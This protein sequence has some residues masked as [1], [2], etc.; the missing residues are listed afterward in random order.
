LI[1]QDEDWEAACESARAATAIYRR[2][3]DF[4]GV[5]HA[6]RLLIKA[7]LLEVDH[8]RLEAH[9]GS[10]KLAR[11]TL[12]KADGICFK[13]LEYFRE[14]GNKYGEASTLWTL[15]DLSVADRGKEKRDQGQAWATEALGMFRELQDGVMEARALMTLSAVHV[16]ESRAD[17]AV[18]CA[19]IAVNICREGDDS[20]ML[21]KALRCLAE[22]HWSKQDSSFAIDILMEALKN[23]RGISDRRLEVSLLETMG[24]WQLARERPREAL[25]PVKEAL[26]ILEDIDTAKSCSV[27]AMKVIVEAY[28]AVGDLDAALRE[29]NNG[30]NQCK[31]KPN[32][33]METI[34]HCLLA[35]VHLARAEVQDALKHGD[36]AYT[37]VGEAYDAK[38]TSSVLQSCYEV[39]CGIGYYEH[40]LYCQQ[41][42]AKLKAEQNDM[43]GE[44]LALISQLQAVQKLG[45]KA[46]QAKHIEEE[47]RRSHMSIFTGKP[48]ID[49]IKL[50]R[51]NIGTTRSL[52][53]QLELDLP[54]HPSLLGKALLELVKAGM[55][56]KKDLLVAANEAIGFFNIAGDLWN[57]AEAWSVLAGVHLKL[58]Q[59]EKALEAAK[60]CRKLWQ[61]G[62]RRRKAAN[63]Y[64]LEGEIQLAMEDFTESM[65]AAWQGQFECKGC[66][67]AHGEVAA[68]IL[69]MQAAVGKMRKDGTSLEKK[70][71]E[72]VERAAKDAKRVALKLLD[73]NL[74]NA[75]FW[76]ASVM[77][78]TGNHEE[79]LELISEALPLYKEL[80][81]TIGEA[82]LQLRASSC[83]DN[84]K[85]QREA[86]KA[87]EAAL[88]LFQEA[89]F[90]EGITKAIAVLQKFGALGSGPSMP[91]PMQMQRPA[92]MEESTPSKGE[93][94]AEESTSQQI[95][96][97]PS[98]DFIK[99]QIIRMVEESMT[100]GEE[101]TGDSAL[102]DAGLDSLAA[103]SFRNSL[104]TEFEVTLPASLIFDYPTISDITSYIHSLADG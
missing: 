78:M 3:G 96:N 52:R 46:L 6:T 28:L 44:L 62:D 32:W 11:D 40:A 95:S 66:E 22:A 77:D 53:G 10:E 99:K 94:N 17:Q 1:N 81:N 19:R 15:A 31:E 87:A 60:T 75:I 84:L 103:V 9:F 97:R 5:A 58:N 56:D 83:Y 23:C 37:A 86:I 51:E 25:P 59:K 7:Y 30:L 20:I 43:I 89:E 34:M 79:A 55:G 14:N 8:V 26:A 12:K 45:T 63:S 68:L 24:S 98:K 91:M 33:R 102:M 85:R 2:L 4:R 71:L 76:H 93:S 29:A 50:I 67:D 80:K 16:E 100:E 21:V 49:A 72:K 36:A 35:K 74:P 47:V 64:L 18:D 27:D 92:L 54:H 38:L 82:G 90:D 70:H 42:V 13:E 88:E 48:I 41:E 69:M 73:I 65:K 39:F 61:K 101:L 57:E 104:A